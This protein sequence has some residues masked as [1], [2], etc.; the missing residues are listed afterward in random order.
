MVL[1]KKYY[2]NVNTECV[3]MRRNSRKQ[4]TDLETYLNTFYL[5]CPA[6]QYGMKQQ[7][8][9]VF[10]FIFQYVYLVSS[11]QYNQ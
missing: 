9:S 2:K 5:Q 3:M 7:I 6:M 4:P 11:L 10:S 8:Y 1:C